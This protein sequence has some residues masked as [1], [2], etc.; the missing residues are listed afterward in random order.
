MKK[1]LVLWGEK[2]AGE[3]TQ[4]VLLALELLAEENKI[5]ALIFEG[6]TATEDLAEELMN[7]WRKG[8]TMPLPEGHQ[9]ADYELS[10]GGSLLPAGISAAEK[11][12]LVKRTQTEWLFIVLS[13][14]LFK[15]YVSELEELKDRVEP[16]TKYSKGIWEEM[17]NFQSKVMTQVKEQNLFKEHTSFLR[18]RINDLFGVLKDLRRV[19]DEAFE[20]KAKENF[21]VLVEGLKKVEEALE[22]NAGAWGKWFDQLKK[23]QSQLKKMK[24]TRDDRASL[25]DRIDK[26]F[27]AVKVKRFGD[28][29]TQGNRLERRIDGLSKAIKKMETSI[30]RDEKELGF[31]NKK[32]NSSHAGQLEA[33]LREVRAKLIVERIESKKEKLDDMQKTMKDLQSR[34]AKLQKRIEEEEAKKKAEAQK[35]KEKAAETSKEEPKEEEKKAEAKVEIAAKENV[36]EVEVS[37]EEAKD[38]V[39]E[40]I[41]PTQE[42][43]VVEVVETEV[44][45]SK[46]EETVVVEEEKKEETKA[47]EEAPEDTTEEDE[48]E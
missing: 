6:E 1:K 3:E 19:E 9:T 46:A 35:A 10:A 17:K 32:M 26:A 36:E 47:E 40:K 30:S 48:K 22:N 4:K 15:T 45:E 7:K 31:Q 2:T 8:E 27:K 25:W 16:L 34:Q 33:Q 43:P 20:K 14:K 11:E 13:T 18:D 42:E 41:E 12:D 44:E 28:N 39:E 5:K 24:L 37:T 38:V 23:L 21:N 29:S